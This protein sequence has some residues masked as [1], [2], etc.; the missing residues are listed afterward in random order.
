MSDRVSGDRDIRFLLNLYEKN[1]YVK[2]ERHG[3]EYKKKIRDET[4]R[5]HRHLIFDELLVEA[6]TL[7]LTQ[8]QINIVRYL[9]D[10]FN[11]EFKQLHRN[12]SEE[13]VV[14]AFMFYVKKIMAPK[15]RLSSY[16]VTSKYKLTNNMFETILCRMLLKF[17]KKCPIVP[18]RNYRGDEH[19][20][21]LKGD[22]R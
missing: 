8:D 18:Y 22:E 4:K 15:T 10:D 14:L 2:G 12:A 13:A 16:K 3:R 1:V 9:I 20:Q 7:H 11:E 21:L 6:E 5:K 19:E 17:M